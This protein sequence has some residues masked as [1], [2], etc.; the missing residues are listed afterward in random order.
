MCI[1]CVL[2]NYIYNINNNIDPSN[3]NSLIISGG[4]CNTQL[5]PVVNSSISYDNC[6]RINI[7]GIHHQN[8]LQ[9]VLFTKYQ[10]YKSAFTNVLIQQ[11]IENNVE[12]SSSIYEL[13]NKLL[14]NLD[15]LMTD[16]EII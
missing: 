11:I 4:H 5:I 6:R 13:H 7:G 14:I 2:P 16:K 12:C 10:Y 9:K 3:I 8:Y 1:D 15:H